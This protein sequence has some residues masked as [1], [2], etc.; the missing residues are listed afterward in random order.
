MGSMRFLI[1]AVADSMVDMT[2]RNLLR[3]E[4]ERMGHEVAEHGSLEG[5]DLRAFDVLISPRIR[6]RELAQMKRR[7]PGLV[8]VLADPKVQTRDQLASSVLADF[9]LVG[10]FEHEAR[11]TMLGGTALRFHWR[12]NLDSFRPVP[13]S[14]QSESKRVRLFYHGNRAHLESLSATA[15]AAIDSLAKTH[16]IVLE[17]HYSKRRAGPWRV[18]RWVRNLE[19]EH[20]DWEEP[21]VW[22]RLALS[23]IGIVPAALPAS[24]IRP[25][26]E[27]RTRLNAWMNPM[28]LRRDDYLLRFKVTANPGRIIPFGHFAKPVV[29]D[30]FPSSAELLRDG[31]D[32]FLA[33]NS[34]Q[35]RRGLEKLILDKGLR[36]RMGESLKNRCESLSHVKNDASRLL[37]A[38]EGNLGSG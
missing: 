2:L 27:R 25:V 18:P 37:R 9:C 17:A 16:S 35:W 4:L 32:G 28:A 22:Q 7:F 8:F 23:D 11:V 24:P 14:E 20:W 3:P 36:Q 13:P 38:L 1:S 31:V 21:T 26:V 10:S 30:F 33:L 34:E 12:P 19:V 29:S 15:L 5:I 6:Y